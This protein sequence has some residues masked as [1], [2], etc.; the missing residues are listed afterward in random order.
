MKRVNSIVSRSCLHYK[1]LDVYMIFKAGEKN[2]KYVTVIT[3]GFAISIPIMYGDWNME[4]A[5]RLPMMAAALN[6]T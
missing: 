4:H 5:L 1:Y 3:Y 6:N 2:D